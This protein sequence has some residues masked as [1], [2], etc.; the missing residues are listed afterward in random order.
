MSKSYRQGQILKLIRAKPIYTQ[1]EL[2]TE[3]KA[4]GIAA[5]QVTLS[6]DLRDLQLVK[7]GTGYQQ[8]NA[9]DDD[10]AAPPLGR[11]LANF[12]RDARLAQNQVVLKT[13]PGHASIIAVALDNEDWPEVVGT[14]AGDDT[15]LIIATDTK[16]A[17]KLRQRLLDFLE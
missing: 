6:R 13:D 5:T 3:L 9:P 8:L 7:T 1:D 12:L 11:L 17:T 10:D 15:V 2:A 16:S 14:I 4:E